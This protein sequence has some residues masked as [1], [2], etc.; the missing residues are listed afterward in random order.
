MSVDYSITFTPSHS[1]I[2]RLLDFLTDQKQLP[3][4]EKHRLVDELMYL[5]RQNV[6]R[7]NSRV[8]KGVWYV[9][10][11]VNEHRKYDGSG[12]TFMK[13]LNSALSELDKLDIN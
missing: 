7:C 2:P 6:R 13:A 1:C 12:D 5:D 10:F 8:S 4:P 11:I 3:L 9:Q